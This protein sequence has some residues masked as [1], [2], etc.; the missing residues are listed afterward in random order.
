MWLVGTLIGCGSDQELAGMDVFVEDGQ[1]R[2][3][4]GDG[5]VSE[6]LVADAQQ[7]AAD[8]IRGGTPLW[9]ITCPGGNDLEPNPNACLGRG[10]VYGELPDDAI[11]TLEPTALQ[12]HVAYW[13]SATGWAEDRDL[14]YFRA[15]VVFKFHGDEVVLLHDGLDDE[16]E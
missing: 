7:P 1:V 5:P 6:L 8:E 12:E 11:E 4:W 3:D 9:S 2:L 16:G 15:D 10:L 13:A 14:P